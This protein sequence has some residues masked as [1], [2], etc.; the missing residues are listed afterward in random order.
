MV[1]DEKIISQKF[2]YLFMMEMPDRDFQIKE[3]YIDS[4]TGYD[5]T[6]HM[7]FDYMMDVD[8]Q[9]E[10]ISWYL[11]KSSEAVEKF[12]KKYQYDFESKSIVENGHLA[13]MEP[14]VF[15]LDFQW[16]EKFLINMVVNI[17]NTN[18]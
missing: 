4:D 18:G 10:D 7:T 13:V 14:L 1:M 9:I 15:G 11:K 16:G 3:L 6:V 17:G 5:Y 12:L 8:P 2:K